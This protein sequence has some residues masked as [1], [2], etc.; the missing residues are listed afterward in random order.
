MFVL[1]FFQRSL[2]LFHLICQ[3]CFLL[4][5]PWFYSSLSNTSLMAH[6][7]VCIPSLLF[8]SVWVSA[9]LF[10]PLSLWLPL[11]SPCVFCEH[12]H[13]QPVLSLSL[14]LTNESTTLSPHGGIFALE[15]EWESKGERE[16]EGVSEEPRSGAQEELSYLLL[17]VLKY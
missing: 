5:P 12:S 14:G 11:A 16:R 7:P 9:S 6:L 17:S 4:S 3:S 2:R 8:S 13:R 10:L 15:S 1:H